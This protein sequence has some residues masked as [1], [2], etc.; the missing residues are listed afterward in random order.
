M[1]STYDLVNQ[2][3]T[4]TLIGFG[5]ALVNV[6]IRYFAPAIPQVI[7]VLGWKRLRRALIAAYLIALVLELVTSPIFSSALHPVSI[8]LAWS[9]FQ[10]IFNVLGVILMDLIVMAWNGMR[11][12]AAIGRRQLV[13][14][15]ERAAE[16]LNEV[17]SRLAISPEGKE[18]HAA[19]ER[20]ATEAAAS[21]AAER[22]QRMDDRLNN[23]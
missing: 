5:L 2:A 6:I 19:K 3:I 18:E 22:K 4:H 9:P 10:A 20:A 13:S 17:G 14:A 21:A 15:R 8:E 7:T 23:Y 11:S 16:G 1:G 12:G